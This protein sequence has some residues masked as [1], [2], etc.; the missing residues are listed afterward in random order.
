MRMNFK[1]FKKMNNFELRSN[2]KWVYN[3]LRE[4]G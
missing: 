3:L 4:D 2:K 1:K